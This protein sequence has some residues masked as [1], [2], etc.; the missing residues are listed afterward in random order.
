MLCKIILEGKMNKYTLFLIT[1]I[2]LS[3]SVFGQYFDYVSL[4]YNTIE[5]ITN[6]GEIRFHYYLTRN[7]EYSEMAIYPWGGGDLM[8]DENANDY[9][10]VHYFNCIGSSYSYRKLNE[11]YYFMGHTEIWRMANERLVYVELDNEGDKTFASEIEY[12]QNG[13]I[14]YLDNGFTQ[15]YYNIPGPE[16]LDK[17]LTLFVNDVF[18]IIDKIGR[19]REYYYDELLTLLRNL[20]QRELAIFRN[21]LFA[22]HQ[23]AFQQQAWKEFMNKY[24][25]NYHGIYINSEVMDKLNDDERWLLNLISGGLIPRRSAA[26]KKGIGK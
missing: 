15:K 17:F 14:V 9:V 23:Y 26:V 18:N 4:G 6:D 24:Y 22:K 3:V 21:C 11:G 10:Y 25:K 16:L 2:G 20:K 19:Y 12:T 7:T 5:T 1:F 13:L 8:F